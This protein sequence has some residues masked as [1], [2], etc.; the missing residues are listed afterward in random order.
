MPGDILGGLHPCPFLIPPEG[1]DTH[2]DM[3]THPHV[4]THVYTQACTHSHT[5]SHS[6]TV[7]LF[8]LP[9][10]DAPSPSPPGILPLRE[11]PTP[12]PSS[13]GRLCCPPQAQ[14]SSFLHLSRALPRVALARASARCWFLQES[15]DR[16]RVVSVTLLSLS[17]ASATEVLSTLRQ[18]TYPH[19]ASVSLY[20]I[21][22]LL[23]RSQ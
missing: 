17:P 20:V 10:C 21:T 12:V 18:F 1:Q 22:Q 23:I 7:S 11:D 6:K 9:A 16:W 19:C 2:T 5:L 13:P 14:E 8:I 15:P 4:C 3:H